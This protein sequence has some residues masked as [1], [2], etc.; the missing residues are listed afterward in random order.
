MMKGS[1][2]TQCC[3]LFPLR[4][5]D[6]GGHCDQAEAVTNRDMIERT[7]QISLTAS[8]LSQATNVLDLVSI[9]NESG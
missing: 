3:E 5:S 4:V 9:Q 6:V 2:S 1:V 8:D 7:M